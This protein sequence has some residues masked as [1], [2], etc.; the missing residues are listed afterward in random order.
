MQNRAREPAANST[1][2]TGQSLSDES[3]SLLV[4]ARSGDDSALWQLTEQLRPYL[5]AV[6]RRAVSP[7]L[8]SKVDDS[9]IVQQALVRAVGKF[10]EFDGQNV[11]QWQAWLVTIAQNE[12]RNAIRFW[13]Q[14][15]RTTLRE[16]PQTQG[17]PGEIPADQSTPSQIAMRRER[18]ARLMRKIQDLPE[19]Q[20]Q[21]I[22]WRHFDN[23]SHKEIAERLGISEDATR[24]R[25]KSVLD[26]L[27]RLLENS[28]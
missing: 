24:H 16:M 8:A 26:R 3:Q 23:L 6:V 21:L 11:E 27:S 12:A 4:Q 10:A 19:D 18:A 1:L 17:P 14:H 9:D 25:W 13:H 2:E 22:T 20:Q 5:K 28:L 7:Q 15:R